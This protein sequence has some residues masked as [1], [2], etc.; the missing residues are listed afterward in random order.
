[1]SQEQEQKDAEEAEYAGLNMDT[2]YRKRKRERES[3][4]QEQEAKRAAGGIMQPC[5]GIVISKNKRESAYKK[6]SRSSCTGAQS[7]PKS[8]RKVQIQKGLE[9]QPWV[10]SLSPKDR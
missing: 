3:M 8:K 7:S 10:G 5:R 9:K 2:V 4:S 6:D 1:M